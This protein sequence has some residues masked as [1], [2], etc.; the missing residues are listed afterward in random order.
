MTLL[1][2]MAFCGF[3]R[4]A[5]L[6]LSG[7][8]IGHTFGVRVQRVVVSPSRAILMKSALRINLSASYVMKNILVISRCAAPPYPAA[9][10]FL[11]GKGGGASHQRGECISTS[12][13]AVVRF[14]LPQAAAYKT[15]SEPARSAG[16][17]HRP[18]RSTRTIEP[19]RRRRLNPQAPKGLVLKGGHHG[20]CI[21]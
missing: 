13:R 16:R 6:P 19:E 9:P 3:A 12:I 11:H 18:V 21:I 20:M 2:H 1:Y 10:D 17:T 5:R 8:A 4:C 15:P 14:S 7:C